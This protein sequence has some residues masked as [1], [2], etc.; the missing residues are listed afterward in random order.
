MENTK[1]TTTLQRIIKQALKKLDI[2][3]EIDKIQLEHPNLEDHGDYST[4]IAMSLFSKIT[5]LGFKSPYELARSIVDQISKDQNIILDKVEIA[6]PGFIN[7]RLS[8]QFLLEQ[9]QL[10]K[11]LGDDY[12]YVKNNNNY[13][14]T[15]LLEHTSPNPNKAMHL[16]HLRNNV[17]GMAIGNIW[18]AT[19]I[20]VIRDCVD[21]DRGI[22]IAK[23]MWGYLKFAHKENKQITDLKYW[24]NHQDQWQTP[25][26]LGVRP[27]LFV[28]NLY[29][30]GADDFKN[31][32]IEKIVR[33]LVVDWEAKDK[34]VW[35][36]WAKV[37]DYSHR[38]QNLTLTRLG[39]KWD[40]VWHEHDHYQEG[41]D[42]V[43]KGLR[44]GIFRK[45][46]DG[47]ILTNLEKDFNLT[48]TIVQKADGTSLYITQDIALTRK[49][50]NTFHPDKMFWVIGPEQSLAMKQA[51]AVCD[52]LGIID[53]DKC[54]HLAYGYMSIKGKGKMSSREG[55]V[56]YI[57]DL[58][59]QVKKKVLSL[60]KLDKLS[61]KQLDELSEMIAVGAVKYSILK[62]GR[63]TNTAFDI[64][65]SISLNG[66]SGPYLQYTYARC[67]SVLRKGNINQVENVNDIA[68]ND[69]EYS[70]LRYLYRFSE[71]IRFSAVEHAPNHI[72]T[73]LYNLA[74]RYNTFYNKHSVL[75]AE[76]D[77]IR[78]FR[79]DLTQATAQIIKNGLYLLGI[80]TPER[81]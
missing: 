75:E 80:E 47:A 38:G 81:M 19:G 20:K 30:K 11:Q 37:L 77:E 46:N 5:E 6:G 66:N 34:L 51:F 57:D 73:Y 8:N 56:I 49:K 54:H 53:Y 7:F 69:E 28:D 64:N 72:C 14:Q 13:G 4:N 58:I 62:N 55:N 60:I 78:L 32:E 41:K 1:I 42:L 2:G 74:Q 44:K 39:N 63:M 61:Q 16:G 18:E 29:I 17:T 67:R 12:G 15:W 26:S 43:E 23:L 36:L 9:L 10:I 21:N 25:D 40:K 50:K 45:L 71:V 35:A 48:D 59:D 22:A 68:I 65:E 76:T 70:L 27:D 52:Q 33:Q 24:Y 3:F 31:P 79:L